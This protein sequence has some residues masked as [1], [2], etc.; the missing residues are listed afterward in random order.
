[1]PAGDAGLDQPGLDQLVAIA[2][3]ARA[4]RDVDRFDIWCESERHTRPVCRARRALI[5]ALA[6]CPAYARRV[7][8]GEPI[9]GW[10]PA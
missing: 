5:A 3:A 7:D 1:V 9:N 4:L 6:A 10:K 2:N 8:G